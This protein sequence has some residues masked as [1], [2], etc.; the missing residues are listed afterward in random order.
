MKKLDEKVFEA[1]G[2]EIPIREETE[3]FQ[4]MSNLD[5]EDNINKNTRIS[6]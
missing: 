6:K 5:S 2:A 4:V 3:L 1:T